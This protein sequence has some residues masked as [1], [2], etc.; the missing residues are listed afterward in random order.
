MDLSQAFINHAVVTSETFICASE[1][2]KSLN[3]LHVKDQQTVKCS[4]C[5]LRQ[6]RGG[7]C[8]FLGVDSFTL[9]I[10]GQIKSGTFGC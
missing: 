6:Y 7:D 2:C 1:K 5:L 9:E 8:M 4:K 10:E 3:N